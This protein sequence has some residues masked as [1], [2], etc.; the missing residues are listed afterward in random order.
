MLARHEYIGSK[1]QTK[2]ETLTT[3]PEDSTPCKCGQSGCVG[4]LSFD[5]GKANVLGVASEQ[6]FW[7]RYYRNPVTGRVIVAGS[8]NSRPPAGYREEHTASYRDVQKLEQTLNEQERAY[9]SKLRERMAMADEAER[10][11]M[12]AARLNEE[13]FR[14]AA[15]QQAQERIAETKRHA[16]ELGHTGDIPDYIPA[17]MDDAARARLGVAIQDVELAK[18]DRE[19]STFE[20]IDPGLHFTQLHEDTPK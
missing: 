20:A 13:E 18:M 1:C 7:T 9:S 4:E 8:A 15:R 12:R 10:K 11:E 19:A 6:A 3:Y 5:W 14:I 16:Q 2:F 17:I